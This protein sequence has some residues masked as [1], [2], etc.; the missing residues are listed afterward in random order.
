MPGLTSKLPVVVMIM[1][2][3]A[4]FMLIPATHALTAKEYYVARVFFY[5]GLVFGFLT[6]FVA[7]TTAGRARDG[8]AR[9]HLLALLA[10]F[11]L[12]PLM[13]AVPV[14]QA[15]GNT[16]FLNAYVEMVSSL[17]TTGATLY[18]DPSRLPRSVHLWRALVGWLGGLIIWVGAIAI[19]AP[20]ALGGFEV[21]GLGGGMSSGLAPRK[22]ALS[23]GVSAGHS[24]ITQVADISDRIRTY[25]VQLAPLYTGLTA[26][27]WIGLIL[28][29]ET[30]FIAF[31]HALSTLSTSGISP[32]GGLSGGD[33][34]RSGELLVAIFLL[35]AISRAAFSREGRLGRSKTFVKDPEVRLAVTLVSFVTV[36]LILRH[37]IGAYDVEEELNLSTGL[38]ALWGTAFTVLGFLT[39]AGFES[40]AWAA[41]RSWSGLQSPGLVLMGLALIGGGVATTAGGAKLLR[42]YALYKHSLREMEKL[43]H[44]SSVGGAGGE[45]RHIRSRGAYLAWVFFMLMT[46]SVAAFMTLFSLTGEGFETSM[47]LTISALTTTGPLASFAAAEPVSYGDLTSSAKLILS[48]AMVMGR[49]ETLAIVALL[50]RDIWRR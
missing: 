28:A 38:D 17:T 35:F 22:G 33:A 44:P 41:A 50:G 16:S 47:I 9:I 15:V 31:C 6:L 32:V 30:P 46:M 8:F 2:V 23:A 29:G 12:L 11:T 37:W 48:A 42:V 24:Q 39:T 13:L 19:L 18:D 34:G 3:F 7:I 5:S 40:D 14:H 27:L 1:G 36:V 4:A 10:V 26:V 45:A 43:V 21:R 20:M 25:S 49:L